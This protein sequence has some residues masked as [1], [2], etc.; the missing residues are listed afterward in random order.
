MT[1]PRFAIVLV[2]ALAAAGA[3]ACGEDEPARAVT[4]E[5]VPF[6]P[7]SDDLAAEI[8][9]R[10]ISCEDARAFIRD[11]DGAPGGGAQGYECTS[12]RVDAD[13]LVH[14]RWRCEKGEVLVTWSRY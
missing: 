2:I 4:C 11:V 5:D 9:A 8:R 6:T 1:I 7:N 12:E 13:T 10:G 14:T 3:G